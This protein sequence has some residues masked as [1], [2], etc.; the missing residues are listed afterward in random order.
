MH[1]VDAV[2]VEQAAVPLDRAPDGQRWDRQN[3]A[4]QMESRAGAAN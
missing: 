4:V 1:V 3:E 2:D